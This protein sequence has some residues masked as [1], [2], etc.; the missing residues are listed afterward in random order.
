MGKSAEELQGLL[1]AASMKKHMG[2]NVDAEV[3]EIIKMC[4]SEKDKELV[5]KICT[6]LGLK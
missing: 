4:Q 2:M 1:V 6:A 3:E 5:I